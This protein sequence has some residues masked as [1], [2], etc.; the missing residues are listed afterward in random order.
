M[1]VQKLKEQEIDDILI[2]FGPESDGLSNDEVAPCDWIVTIPSSSEYR[3]LNLAQ[4]VLVFS[5]EVQ[6]A[7]LEKV[8]RTPKGL[9]PTQKE[10]LV[11][12]LIQLAEEVGFILP[13][14]P[15][16]MRPRLEKLFSGI[17]NYIEDAKTLHGLLD[18][19]RRSVKRGFPDIRGRYRHFFKAP[20]V[21]KEQEKETQI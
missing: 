16:K 7:L 10:R 5:Y 15:H 17:P 19:I 3:S 14:D 2:V 12:H 21:E 4:S 13:N 1:A 8:D 11:Q 20:G 9:H 18:Q 6:R